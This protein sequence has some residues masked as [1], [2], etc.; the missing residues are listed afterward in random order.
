VIVI[1]V[2]SSTGEPLNKG[3]LAGGAGRAVAVAVGG[4]DDAERT[5]VGRNAGGADEGPTGAGGGRESPVG[6][7]LLL[8]KKIPST[9]IREKMNRANR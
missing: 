9:A 2:K 6:P 7:S 3:G 4:T 5:P 1:K 8:V